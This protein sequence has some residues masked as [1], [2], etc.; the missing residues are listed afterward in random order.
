M[1]SDDCAEVFHVGLFLTD[2]LAERGHDILWL[3]Q[4]C[5]SLTLD[6]VKSILERTSTPLQPIECEEIAN[7]FDVGPALIS[8]LDLSYHRRMNR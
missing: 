3:A 4:R 8:N 5:P 1:T 2:E 6:R 7:A